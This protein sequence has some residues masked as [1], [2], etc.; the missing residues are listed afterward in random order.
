MHSMFQLIS[1][2]FIH[3]LWPYYSHLGT[4][5]F[6]F[7]LA[8][9][10][11]TVPY[12]DEKT[13]VLDVSWMLFGWEINSLN[14]PSIICISY[15]WHFPSSH[16]MY[17]LIY[18]V[19]PWVLHV[20][21][22]VQ[23]DGHHGHHGPARLGFFVPL[24]LCA[25]ALLGRVDALDQN[26]QR[27]PW[28]VW[29]GMVVSKFPIGKSPFHFGKSTISMGNPPFFMENH[30]FS[31]EKHHFSLNHPKLPIHKLTSLWEI[32]DFY[33]SKISMGKSTIFHGKSTILPIGKRL[34]SYGKS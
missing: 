6:F 7:P 9:Y 33:K 10:Y 15:T 19:Y 27:E 8:Y 4:A 32:H 3:V 16:N 20:A 30:N 34:H 23:R 29:N 21:P 5:Q 28:A 18:M 12:L 1:R 25:T 31:W 14:V 11:V 24:A 13:L 22:F 26:D 17:N 2:M